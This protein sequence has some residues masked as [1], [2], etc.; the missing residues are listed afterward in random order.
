MWNWA[1]VQR[2]AASGF[3]ISPGGSVICR[4]RRSP[5]VIGAGAFAVEFELGRQLVGVGAG[6]RVGGGVGFGGGGVEARGAGKEAEV[7]LSRGGKGQ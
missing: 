7:G 2:V 6:A 3:S 4:S 1:G 5:S